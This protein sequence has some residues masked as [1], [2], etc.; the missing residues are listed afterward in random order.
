MAG[1]IAAV[2]CAGTL[3]GCSKSNATENPSVG[4]VSALQECEG[5]PPPVRKDTYTVGF[6]TVY[7]PTNPY[8][9]ANTNDMVAEAQKRGYKLVFAPPTTPDVKEQVARMQALVAAKVDAII[10]RPLPDLAANVVDARKACIPVFTEGRAVGPAAVAGK[11]FV[12]HIGTDA[13]I[14]GQTIATWLIKNR[15]KG[16]SII[17]LEGT[18]GSSPAIGRKKGFDEQ[19]A[20][21]PNMKIVASKSG[22]FDRTVGHDVAL[23]LLKEHPKADVVFAHND[24]MALG[25]LAAVKESGKIPGKDIIIIS[26]D[27]LNEAVRHVLDGTIAAVEFNDP[28]LGAVSFD[29][30]EKYA[31][32]QMIP[33][34]IVV[35]GPI[36]DST[37][38]PT[39]IAEAF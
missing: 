14:Q 12:T 7:E 29:T 28:K 23:Q 32:R 13:V 1:A 15:S 20:T 10:A 30:M 27:G 19:I 2:V 26:I 33:P 25:A 21:E 4:S 34:K 5:L 17:E 16:A 36:I 9:V 22:N 24:Y 31:A 18:T 11:D 39:M 3:L 8:T 38:A 35:R 37:N 6:L